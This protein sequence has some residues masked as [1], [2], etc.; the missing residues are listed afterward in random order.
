MR[1]ALLGLAT[2]VEI[3]ESYECCT[4]ATHTNEKWKSTI[5][6]SDDGRTYDEREIQE[7]KKEVCDKV[8]QEIVLLKDKGLPIQAGVAHT[9]VC[10]YYAITHTCA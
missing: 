5:D 1:L 10:M 3:A 6:N 8:S 9:H 2:I 4:A 7:Y